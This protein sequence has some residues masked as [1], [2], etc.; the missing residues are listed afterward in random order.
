MSGTAA[1]SWPAVLR[2]LAT[3]KNQ[4]AQGAR[5]QDKAFGRWLGDFLDQPTATGLLDAELQLLDACRTGAACVLPAPPTP[6]APP[7]AAPP[8]QTGRTDRTNRTEFRRRRIA[9]ARAIAPNR[10]RAA[11]LRFLILQGDANAPVHEA[12][13]ELHNA[14]IVSPG[15]PGALQLDLRGGQCAGRILLQ[16]CVLTG[17]LQLQDARL[18]VLALH[19]S[20]LAGISAD[21][22]AFSGSLRL[23]GCHIG[24]A[25]VCLVNAAIGGSL[26]C[27]GAVVSGLLKHPPA[28]P[29]PALAL[30]GAKIAGGVYLDQGFAADR[31]VNLAGAQIAGPL[32]CR[33]ASFAGGIAA[34]GAA[35]G[36]DAL[37]LSLTAGRG[38]NLAGARIAGNLNLSGARLTP[39]DPAATALDLAR[40]GINGNA[41]FD[42]DEAG[43]PFASQGRIDLA[44][45]EIGG[46]LAFRNA[47]LT[48]RWSKGERHDALDGHNAKLGGSLIFGAGFVALGEICL[49]GAEIARDLNA[50]GGVFYNPEGYAI[51][52]DRAKI[53]GAVLLQA[54]GEPPARTRGFGC[55]SL[56]GAACGELNAA[57]AYLRNPG[58]RALDCTGLALAGSARLL[59]TGNT[60]FEAAGEVRFYFASIGANLECGGGHFSNPGA[61]ALDGQG[62]KIAGCVFLGEA[63]RFGVQPAALAGLAFSADGSVDFTGAAVSLQFN[64]QSG[65][66]GN[67][68]QDPPG[69]GR[70]AVALNLAVATIG[71]TLFLGRDDPGSQPPTIEGSVD[72]TGATA[73][74]LV[75]HGFIEDSRHGFGPPP[76]APAAPPLE[77]SLK[78]D[79][80]SYQRLQGDNACNATRR[81]AWLNRQPAEDL[82]QKFKPQP[83]EQLI[84]VMRAMGYDGDADEIALSKRSF[85]R[86]SAGARG[87][88]QARLAI[89]RLR[90]KLSATGCLTLAGLAW[91]LFVNALEYL[92]LDRCIGYGY[93]IS[94]SVILLFVLT[95]GF[96][97]IYA[98]ADRHGLIIPAER[99]MRA[100]PAEVSPRFN[101]WLYSADV[102]V[103]VIGFGQKAAWMPAASANL[104]YQAQLA[105][106]VIGWIEGF[107]LVAFVTGLIAKE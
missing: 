97:A 8:G 79:Q 101:P 95:G 104:L 75:D 11:F 76:A 13:I 80:F 55:I 103:P 102:I 92:C 3:L 26:Q 7:A 35:I 29:P 42:D 10:L 89:A 71:D 91:G 32:D 60:K 66:F 31:P 24:D 88:A 4:A 2:Q 30:A 107:L 82:G 52:A 72:L 33:N 54:E 74:V 57:G 27:T 53:A 37:L 6:A 58:G 38:I 100:T 83:F 78:L 59:N 49:I 77:C 73:R 19:G 68:A 106:T 65:R 94:R 9:W 105:E 1:Q 84:S 16:N 69:S 67:T 20:W 36:G 41:W 15:T 62:A 48:P 22:A 93:K 50:S 21:R 51:L 96:A 90:K 64:C 39:A 5:P 40:A 17:Q 12:G 28:P 70:A 85:E 63:S 46:D 47:R 25:G 45:A 44:Q 86:Q 56:A 43:T 61:T 98:A 34:P 81:L 14:R 99:D 87:I 18:G 23:N